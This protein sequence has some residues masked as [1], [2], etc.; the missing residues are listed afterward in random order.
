M[1]NR[2][3]TVISAFLQVQFFGKHLGLDICH[4]FRNYAVFAK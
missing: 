4:Y 1:V 2:K 3:F